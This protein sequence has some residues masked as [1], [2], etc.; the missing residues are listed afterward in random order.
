[1]YINQWNRWV[2]RLPSIGKKWL[3]RKEDKNTFWAHSKKQSQLKLFGWMCAEQVKR[4]NDNEII[5]K[6]I[7]SERFW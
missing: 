5:E 4:K 3:V 6:V 2:E 7:F 1:M